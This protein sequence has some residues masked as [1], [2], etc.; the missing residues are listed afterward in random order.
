MSRVIRAALLAAATLAASGAHAARPVVESH[1]YTVC[2]PAVSYV[3]PYEEQVCYAEPAGYTV[4]RWLKRAHFVT[5]PQDCVEPST[6]GGFSR[7]Y[8]KD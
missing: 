5:A 1:E 7:G 8:S 3:A 6:G 2:A 4:C